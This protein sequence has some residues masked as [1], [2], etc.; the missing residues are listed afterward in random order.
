VVIDII[1]I[2]IC[3]YSPLLKLMP[4]FFATDILVA[5]RCFQQLAEVIEYL[6][7][8]KAVDSE[9]EFSTDWLGRGE[10]YMRSLRFKRAQPSVG[11]LAICA[12]KLSHYGNRLKVE[13]KHASISNQL[14]QLSV[15][16]NRQINY[17]SSVQWMEKQ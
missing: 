9:S 15:A 7:E 14:L 13:Q 1:S 5:S 6:K 4:E 2:G 16:C 12:S 11:T 17:E 10:C 8:I 3:A